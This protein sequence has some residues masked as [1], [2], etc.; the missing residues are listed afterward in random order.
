LREFGRLGLKHVTLRLL[1]FYERER[2]RE[3]EGAI[4]RTYCV[5]R[6]PNRGRTMEREKRP[7]DRTKGRLIESR[8]FRV[9]NIDRY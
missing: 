8:A 7:L 5:S 1:K 4:G 2:A 6:L 3:R 9:M